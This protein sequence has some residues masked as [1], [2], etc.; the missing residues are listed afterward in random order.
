[1][2]TITVYNGYTVIVSKWGVTKK[3]TDNM[4][5]VGVSSWSGKAVGLET[6]GLRARYVKLGLTRKKSINI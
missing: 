6:K 3:Q 1:M 2:S 4:P 5:G